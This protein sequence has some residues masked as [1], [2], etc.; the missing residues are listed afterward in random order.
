MYYNNITVKAVAVAAAA[1]GLAALSLSR[2][3]IVI[4]GP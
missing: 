3:I 4:S 1:Q 2:E